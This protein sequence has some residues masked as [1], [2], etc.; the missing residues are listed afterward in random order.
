MV[1]TLFAEAGVKVALAKTRVAAKARAVTAPHSVPVSALLIETRVFDEA[2][3]ATHS[4]LLVL[5]ALAAATPAFVGAAP[6][7]L[8]IGDARFTGSIGQTG[9]A[10]KAHAADVPAA[11]IAAFSSCTVG[12]ADLGYPYRF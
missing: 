12:D 2:A 1:P 10:G 4:A 8:A 5:R 9:N 7:A 3:H 6:L 11:I